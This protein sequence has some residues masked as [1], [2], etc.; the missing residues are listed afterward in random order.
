[1]KYPGGG[2]A[3]TTTTSGVGGSTTTPGHQSTVFVEQVGTVTALF[4]Q[5]ND[6]ERTVVLY[7][8]LKRLPFSNLKFLQLSIEYNI[9]Q[10]IN[11]FS[12]A[13][14]AA[15]A[16]QAPSTT[17]TTTTTSHSSNN[18]NGKQQQTT[19][20]STNQYA[21]ATGLGSNFNKF[22]LL[23]SNS[24]NGIFLTKLIS[25]YKNFRPPDLGQ[26]PPAL[27]GPGRVPV[28]YGIGNVPYETREDVLHD[29]LTYLPLLKPGNEE[30]KAAY[31]SLVPV[32]VADS[33][34][35]A[36][37]TD[38]VQQILSYLLIHPAVTSEDR[39]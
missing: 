8:L 15:A 26:P 27:D 37:P 13:V 14:T 33:I 30:A 3:T 16:T 22:H 12:A 29:I 28:V 20:T 24:N 10:N 21:S 17:T 2:S 39:R 19:T 4:D 7:A 35:Q 38:L 34:K 6:C 23:E 32:V 11:S 9:A 1:M 36:V 18:N 25:V 31:I 5:W